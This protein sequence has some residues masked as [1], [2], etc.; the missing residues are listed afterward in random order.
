V[1]NVFVQFIEGQIDTLPWCEQPPT[2]ET[3]LIHSNIKFV[4]ENGYLTINSQ[5]RVDGAPSSDPDVGWGGEGGYVYQKAYV[6]FFC[7]KENLDRLLAVF[8]LFPTLTYHAV[9]IQGDE[10]INCG[11]DQA[12]AVTWGVFPGREIVQPT[13]V[14]PR[15]FIAWSKEAFELWITQWASAYEPESVSAEVIQ[16]I[17]ATYY[18]VNIVDND[19]SAQ[20]DIFSVFKKAITDA[21]REEDLRSRVM[22]LETENDHLREAV[23]S[24]RALHA[25]TQLEIRSLREE[26]AQSRRIHD[27]LKTQVHEM[28]LTY[29]LHNVKSAVSGRS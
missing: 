26:L 14:D 24:L 11:K 2:R 13:I 23:N 12:N 22:H 4:N 8:H 20:A 27:S 29:T 16:R 3:R 5:P 28:K 25:S 9:N 19:Y 7:S 15:S 18:L 6:E 21:M 1:Y 17:N 10:Y